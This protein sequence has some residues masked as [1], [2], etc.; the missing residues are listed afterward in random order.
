MIIL[1]IYVFHW[2]IQRI[3]RPPSWIF[4]IK[5]SNGRYTLFEYT[6]YST[7][8]LPITTTKQKPRAFWSAAYVVQ[9]VEQAQPWTPQY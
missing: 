2:R 6:E 4:K 9:M 1:I 7:S 5:I 8:K 3:G